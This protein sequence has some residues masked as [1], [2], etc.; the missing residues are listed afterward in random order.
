MRA[1]HV[2]TSGEHN[3]SI[4][5][6]VDFKDHSQLTVLSGGTLLMPLQLVCRDHICTCKGQLCVRVF[7]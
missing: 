2:A 1:A 6:H 3:L 5:L 7:M 4:L